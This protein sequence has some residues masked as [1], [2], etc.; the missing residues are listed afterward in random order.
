MNLRSTLIAAAAAVTLL[1]AGSIGAVSTASAQTPGTTPPAA[2]GKRQQLRD[3]FLSK[4][5]ANLNV[6]LD[7]FKAAVKSAEL[8]TV[9]DLV[10]DG[11]LTADQGAKMKDKINSNDG[12]AIGRFLGQHRGHYKQGGPGEVRERARRLIVVSSAKAIGITPK[13]LLGDLKGGQSIADVAAAHGVSLDV[14]KAAITADAKAALDKAVANGKL[15][16]AKEDAML[17]K[18]AAQLDT[19]LNKKK[20]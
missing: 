13:E 9:D 19:I 16:Q 11:T 2:A 20:S 14:V 10:A 4:L 1:A 3:D 12:L 7:Q 15:T 8:Q 6:S 5:A 17:Q 18:L